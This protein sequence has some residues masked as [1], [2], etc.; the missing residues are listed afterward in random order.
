MKYLPMYCHCKIVFYVCKF[1]LYFIWNTYG[2]IVI[3]YSMFAS[4]YLSELSKY[5]DNVMILYL[6]FAGSYAN[7]ASVESLL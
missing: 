6:L 3:L 1:V 7:G 2:V 4:L 5:G